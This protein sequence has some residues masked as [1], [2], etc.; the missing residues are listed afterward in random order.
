M[1]NN[2]IIERLI[3][4]HLMKFEKISKERVARVNQNFIPP[5]SGIWIRPNIIPGINFISGIA[6]A[7]CTREIG[8]LTIQVF[9]RVNQGTANIKE[10]CDE[11]GKHLSYYQ[12]YNLELLSASLVFV[13]VDNEF[14][15]YNVI[16]PYRYN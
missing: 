1:M 5:A 10:F 2:I 7:P 13:A 14:C 8:T 9:D 12:I 16:L 15:Q 3:M 6:G 11:L 4:T